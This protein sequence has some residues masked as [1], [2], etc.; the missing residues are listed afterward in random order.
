MRWVFLA[1]LAACAVPAPA[2]A[3]DAAESAR[4][5]MADNPFAQPSPLAYQ[6]P[7]FDRIRDADYR[8]AF[9]AGMAEQLREVASI[10]AS[11]SSPRS[12][13]P[14]SP[15]PFVTWPEREY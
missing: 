5:S 3:E 14:P 15:P 1:I 7:P 9:A 2:A 13:V 4:T 10:A 12:M 6:M 11:R 8:P